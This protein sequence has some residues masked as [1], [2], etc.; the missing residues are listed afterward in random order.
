MKTFRIAAGR[1]VRETDTWQE[2]YEILC[3]LFGIDAR[4]ISGSRHAD[5]SEAEAWCELL[6][7]EGTVF[8]GDGFTIEVF[9]DY[10][11]FD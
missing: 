7:Y 2:V 9:E 11:N 6:C 3:D 10:Q 5:F 4:Q 8:E 1:K